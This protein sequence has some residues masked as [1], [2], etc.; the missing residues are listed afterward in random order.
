MSSDA[1]TARPAPRQSSAPR[2]APLQLFDPFSQQVIAYTKPDGATA[3]GSSKAMLLL[4]LVLFSSVA[5]MV[6]YMLH[7]LQA[8]E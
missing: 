2:Q 8:S 6:W 1:N 7:L 4:Q 3:S 5:V